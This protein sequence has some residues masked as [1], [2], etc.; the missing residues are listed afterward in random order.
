[1]D[2]FTEPLQSSAFYPYDVSSLLSAVFDDS[3]TKDSLSC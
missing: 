2:K 1:M 3:A